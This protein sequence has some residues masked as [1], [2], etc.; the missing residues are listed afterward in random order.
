MTAGRGNTLIVDDEVDLRLLLLLTIDTE[1]HGLQVVGEASSGPPPSAPGEPATS[2]APA[3]VV[4]LA[5]AG[6]AGGGFLWWRLRRRSG[7]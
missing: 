4:G 6:L 3:L 5:V 7:R 1:N 2:A